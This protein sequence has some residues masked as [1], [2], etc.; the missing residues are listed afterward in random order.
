MSGSKSY[1]DLC[2]ASKNEEEHL[3]DLKRWQEYAQVYAQVS[4]SHT[5]KSTA[6]TPSEKPQ[7][8]VVVHGRVL[9]EALRVDECWQTQQC[10]QTG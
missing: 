3:M 1:Q 6:S 7:V 9:Q 4:K 10:C 2:I 8:N 5:T